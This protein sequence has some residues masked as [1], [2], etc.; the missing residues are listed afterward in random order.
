ML[1]RAGLTRQHQRDPNTAVADAHLVMMGGVE[2][3]WNC[4]VRNTLTAHPMA[5]VGVDSRRVK[6]CSSPVPLHHPTRTDQTNRDLRAFDQH[7]A[8]RML[9]R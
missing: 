7:R 1:K 6:P 2:F 3:G 4:P 9:M 5:F 8:V